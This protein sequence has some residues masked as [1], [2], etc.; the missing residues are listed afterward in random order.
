MPE[1]LLDEDSLAFYHGLAR[2]LREGH[3]SPVE[4][5][6][7]S[8]RA[9]P[10]P[11]VV[12]RVRAE[13]ERRIWHSPREGWA[14]AHVA[15][16]AAQE[17]GRDL[18]QAECAPTLARALNALGRFAEAVSILHSLSEQLLAHSWPDRVDEVAAL[19]Q[20]LGE[21]LDILWGSEATREALL[22]LSESG[23]LAGYDV[24]HF[25]THA[26]L[27]H[28]APS[29]CRVLLADD[30]LAWA[31]I[32]NLR[33]GAR[34]VVLSTCEGAMGRQYPGDEIMGLARAF[35]LAIGLP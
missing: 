2:R 22:R 31:D 15:C 16:A 3:L 28:L 13:A 34:V 30:S 26:V 20:I 25:A 4:A 24:I 10:S 33:L 7:E 29:Q 27:D 1:P 6:E 11:A 17:P 9:L 19:R 32:L 5:A 21:R 12:E 18:L 23:G 14:L 35:F 8:R